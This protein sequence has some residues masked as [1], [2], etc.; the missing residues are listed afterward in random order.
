MGAC[1]EMGVTGHVSHIY[2]FNFE[3][4]VLLIFNILSLHAVSSRNYECVA[5]AILLVDIHLMCQNLFIYGLDM[6]L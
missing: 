6:G 4:S 2:C 5:A 1:V 3:T